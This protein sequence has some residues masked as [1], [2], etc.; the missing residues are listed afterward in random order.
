MSLAISIPQS[1]VDD[2]CWRARYFSIEWA[3]ETPMKLHSLRDT[4]ADGAPR[5]TGE[6]QGYLE[7]ALYAK[8]HQHDS[9]RQKAIDIADDPRRR[10]TKAFRKLREKAP[11]EF[12]AVYGMCVIDQVG[13]DLP[14]RDS[15]GIRRQFEASVR[16]TKQRLNQ[17]AQGTHYEESDVLILVVSGI[18][19]VSMWAG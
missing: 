12:D 17:R 15:E 1:E 2:A 11:R 13:R 19:K 4:G 3:G 9:S 10:V 18:R 6:F 8:R 14:A 16:R 7:N 5:M